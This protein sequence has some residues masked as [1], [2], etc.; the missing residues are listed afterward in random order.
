MD[1]HSGLFRPSGAAPAPLMIHSMNYCDITWPTWYAT[2]LTTII[3]PMF[4]AV[5]TIMV[6]QFCISCSII[7]SVSKVRLRSG[8]M[9][10]CA[11]NYCFHLHE[12]LA[13]IIGY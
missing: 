1:P 2:L 9:F 6:K 12:I 10:F 13:E 3:A 7:M 5:R 8:F 11:G 4:T